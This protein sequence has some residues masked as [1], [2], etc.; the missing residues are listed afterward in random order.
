[1]AIKFDA[2]RWDA[3][4]WWNSREIFPV[5]TC[6]ISGFLC[7]SCTMFTINA[8]S[9]SD[10]LSKTANVTA[11]QSNEALLQAVTGAAKKI[12]ARYFNNSL[13]NFR[14]HSGA[15]PRCS[16]TRLASK[17]THQGST[18][19]NLEWRE[20]DLR[21]SKLSVRVCVLSS[22]VCRRIK[23]RVNIYCINWISCSLAF[24]VYQFCMTFPD[25][26]HVCWPKDFIRASFFFRCVV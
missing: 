14:R 10:I 16:G 2:K 20:I 3:E 7:N 26:C 8:N 22:L 18:S 19:A 15:I 17:Q 4:R 25:L 24:I 21:V 11:V 13:T 12:S 9:C 1:M 23:V 6:I 5:S